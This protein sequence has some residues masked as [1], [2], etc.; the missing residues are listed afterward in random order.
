MRL[1]HAPTSRHPEPV[2]PERYE[3]KDVGE[4]DFEYLSYLHVFKVML[5]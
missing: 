1:S 2:T 4:E 3:Q 5:M